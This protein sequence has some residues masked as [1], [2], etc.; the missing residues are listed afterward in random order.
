VSGAGSLAVVGTGIESASQLS[1]GA[2]AAMRTAD[3][4]FYQVADPVTELRVRDLCADARSLVAY[5]APDKRRGESYREI[6]DAV[7]SEVT[8]GKHVCLVLYGHPGFYGAVAHEAV[9]RVRALRLPARMLPAVSALDCLF[10]DLGLDPAARGVQVYEATY[11]FRTA[12]ALDV[13]ATLV[14]LQ[15]GIL[16]ERGSTPT[17]AV[18][19]RFRLLVARLGEVYGRDREAVLYEASEYPALPPLT[20]RFRLGCGEPPLPTLRSTLCV[21]APPSS[22]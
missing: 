7:T 12:P 4:T 14:L 22:A 17:P 15:P 8:A 13:A 18:A 1:V 9:R 21:P 11:F 19:D 3:V 6:C 5:F 10:A 2:R 16:G 20:Q